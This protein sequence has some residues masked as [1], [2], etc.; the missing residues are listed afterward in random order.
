MSVEISEK[1][2]DEA[3]RPGVDDRLALPRRSASAGRAARDVGLKLTG[4]LIALAA[5]FVLTATGLVPETTLPSPGQVFAAAAEMLR[6]GELQE[7]LLVSLQ[8]AGAGLL[9]GVVTGVLLALLSGLSRTGEVLLDSNLQMLRAMPILA[10]VPLAIVWFGIGEEV[11]I[12]LV[13][14]GVTFPVYLNTHAAIR[15]VDAR[16]VDLAT[17]V[18]L[19]RLALIRRVVL[20]GAL[21]G[22]FTGLRFAVAIAWLV[23]VVSEQINASSG[24]GYL[25]TQ[26]RSISAT[27]VIV[28]GLV[29]YALLGLTSDTLVRL[30]ER[31]ALSWR[32]TLQAR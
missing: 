19:S 7:H 26:A 24:I 29:V 5:W 18:G 30:I 10:L 32:S 17:T 25:M 2:E 8:R 16:Y 13:A 23:L 4:P 20:P 14:L 11:K 27:D 31:R 9:I 22:F 12:V 28:V 21:P 15:S 3:L 6:A 1:I